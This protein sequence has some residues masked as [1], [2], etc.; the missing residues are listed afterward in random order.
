MKVKELSIERASSWILRVGVVASVTVMLTGI[1]FS[2]LHNHLSVE[3]MQHAR[4]E[5]QAAIVWS[6]MLK[7]SGKAIVELGIY[8][9]VLTPIMRVAASLALFALKER[10]GLYAL[11]T[12]I[13]LILTIVG[14]MAP[15]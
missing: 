1:A 12:L 14:L 15:L 7:G 4:F 2:S 9:L 10:D 3:R 13:V 5:Y 8:I 11:I 6:G